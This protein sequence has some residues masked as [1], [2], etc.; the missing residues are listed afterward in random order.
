MGAS[1]E[2]CNIF[3]LIKLG[4]KYPDH[5]SYYWKRLWYIIRYQRKLMIE[6]TFGPI[7]C[8]MIGHILYNAAE[9]YDDPP[10]MACK[11]CHRYIKD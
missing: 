5:R 2:T 8:W 9:C 10:E 7:I 1:R 3:L 11:R 6:D 4:F